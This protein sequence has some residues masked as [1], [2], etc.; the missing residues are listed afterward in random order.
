MPKLKS[1]ETTL[2]LTNRHKV[3]WPEEGYTKGDLLDY[4]REIV[5]VILPHLK[6]RPQSLAEHP[7]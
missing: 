3:F 5:P 1:D 2:V 4:Y 6:D 7:G